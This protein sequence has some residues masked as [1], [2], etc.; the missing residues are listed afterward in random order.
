MCLPE[1]TGSQPP[2]AVSGVRGC[3]LAPPSSPGNRDLSISAVTRERLGASESRHL[4]CGFFFF[5]PVS[6]CA[7]KFKVC[8]GCWTC[9][10]SWLMIHI[11]GAGRTLGGER[12]VPAPHWEFQ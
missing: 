7:L 9:G 6:E 3:H 8:P 12:G 2:M 1:V 11:T 10:L 4:G 5:F